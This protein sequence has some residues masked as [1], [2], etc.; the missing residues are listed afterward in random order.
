MSAVPDPVASDRRRHVGRSVALFAGIW[1]LGLVA[2]T[3]II[4]F[5]NRVDATRRAQVEIAALHTEQATLT[6]IAFSPALVTAGATSDPRQTALQLAGAKRQYQVHLASLSSLGHG[7]AT[8]RVGAA[9][10]RYFAFVDRLSRLVGKGQQ[11]EAARELG[12]GEQPAGAYGGLSSA[13][14]AADSRFGADASRSRQVATAGTAAAIVFLLLAFSIALQYT[15]SARR[16]SHHDATTDALTG[17]GN[18]RKL[19]EDMAHGFGGLGAREPLALGI[20]DLDGFK[21]YNDTFGHPAGDALLAR[22]GSR[23]DAAVGDAGSAYRIGGDEFIVIS[24]A[25]A[26]DRLLGAAQSAL[27]DSGPG[28]TIHCSSGASRIADGVTLEQALHVAD[29]RLYANKTST[30]SQ[31]G[32]GARD[33]LLQVLAEQN[34]D[35]ATHLGHVADL[36][37]RTAAALDLPQD[38]VERTRLAAEL[39]D[40]G[41]AAIPA[42]ILDKPGPLDAAERAFVER[43]SAIGERIV[44]AAPALEAIAPIVRA[45]HE[46]PDGTGYPDGLLLDQIPMPA[47]II[48]V[49]DAFD[50]MTND[51]PYRT[52]MPVADAVAELRRHAGSQFD[53]T[54]VEAF[55][56][57]IAERL[58]MP[59]AA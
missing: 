37:A 32:S 41:K 23:L 7:D 6:S 14:D 40:V 55:A 52:A 5:Q 33:A 20:F 28:F 22:L 1:L 3:A 44:A 49:V 51:R 36:A 39:H 19:F 57:A 42:W 53:T 34:A 24:A 10:V 21:A 11:V 43:H 35:L 50:A 2:L 58:A 13:L 12:T 31:P 38:Q 15:V 54:V 8:G 25:A 26:G 17:L 29:Q 30:R 56:A 18:R 9:S 16:R 48:A 45:A 4:I 46:R 27:T 59:Q 47:R